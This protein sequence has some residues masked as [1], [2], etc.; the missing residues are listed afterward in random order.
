MFDQLSLFRL[1][2]PPEDPAKPR[3]I[4]LG[5]R[6]VAYALKRGRRRTLGMTIDDRGLRVGVPGNATLAQVEQF[7]RANAEWVLEKLDQY[8]SRGAQRHLAIRHGTRLP[9]L[10]CDIEVR[11]AVGANRVHWTDDGCLI[12]ARPDADLDA[13]A[14]RALKRRALE[15]FGERL[16]HYA[17]R[18]GR[19]A[20]P[21]ALTSARTRWGSCSESSG[22]RLNWRLIHLP[23]PLI[24][25]GVAHELAH[26][27]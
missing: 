2:P 6:I 8:A 1:A 25:Y 14:R 21:L 19:P 12:A 16:A 4:L 23:L 7:I 17:A 5:G 20:P 22:I 24:D 26:L 13:L 11:V 10:G 9:V 3:H 15:V 18:M 27:R